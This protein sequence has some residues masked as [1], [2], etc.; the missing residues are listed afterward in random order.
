MGKKVK[1]LVIVTGMVSL[2][3]L[4]SLS[5]SMT[6]YAAGPGETQST[7]TVSKP[8][9]YNQQSVR[10]LGSW[11]Q[12]ANGTWKFKSLDGNYLTNAWL[13]SL[14]EQ[15]A[16]YYVDSSGVMLTNGNTPDNYYVD[17]SGV[18]RAGNTGSSSSGNGSSSSGG[19]TSELK[20]DYD[21]ELSPELLEAI[22]R[23]AGAS[24]YGGLH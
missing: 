8:V 3:L 4:S 22:K 1:K 13:E 9:T 12:Q 16:Y 19:G 21:D 10:A 11:E 2:A 23:N 20:S 14:S 5:G 15:G 17:N 6:S 7:Q 24:A 18:W